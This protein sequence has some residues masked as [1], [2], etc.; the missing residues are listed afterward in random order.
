MNKCEAR[1]AFSRYLT[2]AYS[3]GVKRYRARGNWDAKQKEDGN[4]ISF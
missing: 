3:F 1:V 2:P 4:F